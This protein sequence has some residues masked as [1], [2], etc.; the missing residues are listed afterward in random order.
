MPYTEA[1]LRHVVGAG[2]A[3]QDLLEQPLVLENPSTYVQFAGRGL[4]RA[5][6]LQELVRRT[7]C[8]L[9]VDVNNVFVCAHNHGFDAEAY[10]RA[11]AVGRTSSTSTWPATP[12]TTHRARHPRPPV[13]GEVWQLYRQAHRLSGGRST[14][15]EWDANVPDFATTHREAKK[16]LRHRTLALR[17]TVA[18][19]GRRGVGANA[20]AERTAPTPRPAPQRRPH[21]RAQVRT[22]VRA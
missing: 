17:E 14:L 22:E 6:F 21:R 19:R 18:E 12:C 11:C 10:L 16:A 20:R 9:L 13:C 3:V 5:E 1:A 2:A 7:G 4:H 8:G 15:L